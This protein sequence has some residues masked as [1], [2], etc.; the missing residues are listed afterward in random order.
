MKRFT[1][2]A[3]L[4]LSIFSFISSLPTQLSAQVVAKK[5]TASTGQ[6]VPF[7]QAKPSTH[8]LTSP[9]RKY[10]M[11]IFLHGGGSLQSNDTSLLPAFPTPGYAPVWEL[12]GWGPIRE[13]G[14][15]SNNLRA[16]WN[17]Q[18]DSF[19]VLQPLGPV[20]NPWPTAYIDAMIKYGTDSLKAD[21]NRIYLSGHSWGGAG[22][23][24]YLNSSSA[25][26]RKLAAAAPIAAWN[27]GLHTN[28]PNY[29]SAAKLPVWGFHAYD[30]ATTKRDTTIYS[31]NRLNAVTPDVKPLLTIWPAGAVI[32]HPHNTASEY[33]FAIH[34]YPY[35]EDGVINIYEWFLGQNNDSL[36]NILPV[37]RVGNDTTILSSSGVANLNGSTSTD[38]DG[39]IVRYVWRKISGPAGGTIATPFGAASSTTV[40][41]LTTVGVYKYQLNAVDHRAAIARDTL[42]ITVED[43]IGYGKALSITSIGGRI[44]AGNV[45]ELKNAAAFTIEVLFKYDSTVT[46]WTNAE[47]TIFRSHIT[48]TDR[49]K[50]TIDKAT[51]SVHFIVANGA[52]VQGYTASNVVSHDT[53]CHVA[54]VFDGAQTGNAN[55]MKIYI[56]GAPQ[57]LSFTGTIPANTSGS[58]PV[59]IFGGEPS[60][61]R[62]TVIDEVRVWDSVVAPGTIDSW[63]DKLLGS[64]HPDLGK[65]TVYW[66]LN[67]DANPAS[68]AA[69]LGTTYP[70]V[71]FNGAYVN[72]TLPVDTIPC[73]AGKALSI[74]SIGGRIIAGNVAELKNASA[75]TIEAQFKYDSTFT[76]WT[77]AEATIFRSHITATDRI[78]L[79]IDKATRS[80][81]FIV[82]NGADV[83]GYT[84]SNVVSHDTWYHVAAVF[85]GAQTGNINRMKIYVNGALQTLSFT[86]TIPANTS[87]ST[88]VC[89]FGG[90]PSAARITVID[91]VRVWDTVLVAD[92]INFWKNKS[93]GSCHHNFNNLILYWPLND[94]AN[95][96]SAAVALGTIYPGVIYNGVYVGSNQAAAA[97]DCSG[98]R[99]ALLPSLNKVEENKPFTGKIYPNP[100]RG[101]VQI[102]LHAPV[103]KSVTVNVL[104]MFGRYLYRDQRMLVKGNNIISLNMAPLPSGTYIIEVGDGKAIQEKY[105]VLKR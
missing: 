59:C 79:T 21:T 103:S 101:L 26:A 61:A 1:K 94:D 67:N 86:G 69:A 53:W 18:T 99:M 39:T 49:I 33:V 9:T 31:I 88:P 19:I 56:N 95:P 27:T 71:I 2:L 41:G 24:N 37:A 100:T 62:L 23:F 66:P 65:L 75:F 6:V 22:V 87:G 44:I 77:N 74:T 64:C 55:R 80:V 50:L 38:A 47:A 43:T 15:Q 82:A 97:S 46:D 91:E 25:N 78:K 73:Y 35:L 98:A 52:D 84:A 32:P 42:T 60:A 14:W 36:P 17:N 45:A 81:Q 96:A 40:S 20:T 72:A 102:E 58:T 89:I 76:D 92:T 105:K 85:D 11:I 90:E 12:N 28:G 54:A 8:D 3:G 51:K 83:K 93:L 7:L 30:D 4:C 48:A 29:V 70:G 57:T 63:K 10:P 104:D 68:A 5:V 13:V 34:Q 16:T